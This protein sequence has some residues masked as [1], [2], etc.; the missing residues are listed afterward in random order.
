MRILAL[1]KNEI[2][3]IRNKYYPLHNIHKLVIINWLEKDTE[4][5]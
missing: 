5:D 3:C 1:C 2:L 4:R